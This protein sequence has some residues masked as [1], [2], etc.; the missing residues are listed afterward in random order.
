MFWHYKCRSPSD[1]VWLNQLKTIFIR[2]SRSTA[3]Y[4][5]FSSALLVG[6]Q[7]DATCG[8]TLSLMQI[9]TLGHLD[10]VETTC[11]VLKTV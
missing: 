11:T 5:L 4:I 2:D 7:V 3:L 9:R 10:G 1:T 8:S 6:V